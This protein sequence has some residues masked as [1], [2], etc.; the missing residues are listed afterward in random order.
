MTLERSVCSDWLTPIREHM[1]VPT[2]HMDAH[3]LGRHPP[4]SM[5]TCCLDL[6]KRGHYYFSLFVSF[7][8]SPIHDWNGQLFI[9][10]HSQIICRD[11]TCSLRCAFAHLHLFKQN[12]TL[13]QNRTYNWSSLEDHITPHHSCGLTTPAIMR[14]CTHPFRHTLARAC[15]TLRQRHSL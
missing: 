14:C 7:P 15:R 4:A 6:F 3:R 10:I 1:T 5:C 2:V 9:H 8:L 13:V 11:H 12:K